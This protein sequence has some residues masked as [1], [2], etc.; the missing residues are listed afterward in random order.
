[1]T[2]DLKEPELSYVV[3]E[4]VDF[5]EIATNTS[6]EKP[7]FDMIDARL[8]RRAALKGVAAFTAVGAFGA[9]LFGSRALAG[10]GK[11]SLTFKEVPKALYK[12]LKVAPGY[13]TNV[14]MRWGDKIT[15][16]APD[17]DVNNQSAAAQEKQYGQAND[18]MAY[19]P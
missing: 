11:S 4:D 14:L 19:F 8:S 16:D 5:D 12:D 3:G 9:P 18:Y 1:M 2:K 13:S 6:K 15:A 10:T 7:L 17:W